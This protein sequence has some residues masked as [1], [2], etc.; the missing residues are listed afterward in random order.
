MIDVVDYVRAFLDER[1]RKRR[2]WEEFEAECARQAQ[3]YDEREA[4][5]IA[6]EAAI[7]RKRETARRELEDDERVARANE[8]LA[9]G[10][11]GAPM[12]RSD[13]GVWHFGTPYCSSC[14]G[15]V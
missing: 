12:S 4:A 15:W 2:E 3:E 5:R 14:S 9:C 6:K 10:R 8:L 7:W 13:V 1:A 11:C